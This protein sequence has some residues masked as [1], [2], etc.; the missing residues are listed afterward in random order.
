MMKGEIKVKSE[1]GKGTSFTFVLP[2]KLKDHLNKRQYR[3]P[4]ASYFNKRVLVI[5]KSTKNIEQ[6][7]SMFG[8]FKYKVHSIHRIKN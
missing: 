6:L 5:D 8:Y 1:I 4:S 3:L 7:S 2:F